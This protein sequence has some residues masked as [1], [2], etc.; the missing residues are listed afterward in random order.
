MEDYFPV[1][2]QLQSGNKSE[3]HAI[4]IYKGQIY[5]L[6]SQFVLTKTQEALNSS[7]GTFGFKAHMHLYRLE[8]QEGKVD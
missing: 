4:C 8:L 1:V 5:D 7:C 2:V 3:T 6:A